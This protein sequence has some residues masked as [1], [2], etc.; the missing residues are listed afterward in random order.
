MMIEGDMTS[1]S[2]VCKIHVCQVPVPIYRGGGPRKPT[3]KVSWCA[4]GR[5][6][7]SL[8]EH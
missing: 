3:A 8:W 6:I 5:I 2:D 7:L 1:R 4:W